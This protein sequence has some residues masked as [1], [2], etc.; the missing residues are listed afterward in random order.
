MVFID[1]AEMICS[2]QAV[3]PE[4]E[5]T[6][7]FLYVTYETS[8]ATNNSKSGNHPNAKQRSTRPL[9]ISPTNPY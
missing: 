8:I 3:C 4:I 9:K 7:L 6:I 1:V 5:S 2:D